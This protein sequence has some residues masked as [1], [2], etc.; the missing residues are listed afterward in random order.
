MKKRIPKFPKV[1]QLNSDKISQITKDIF[2]NES[3]S[4]KISDVIFVFGGSHPGLWEKSYEAYNKGLGKKIITTGGKKPNVKRHPSWN[5]DDMAEAEVIANNLIELGVPER[6]ILIEDKSIHSLENILFGMK[7]INLQNIKR[8]LFVCKS[9]ASGRQ[10]RT[11][12]KNIPDDPLR[13]TQIQVPK[14]R[15]I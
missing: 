11:M 13:C 5:Y 6:D 3:M 12:R 4:P 10:Y 1:P 14:I 15:V 2:I 8:I 9:Y 7:K